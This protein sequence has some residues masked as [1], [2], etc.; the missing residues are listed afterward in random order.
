[1][2]AGVSTK[3][4]TTASSPACRPSAAATA[5]E[6]TNATPAR[7]KPAVAQT[8]Q[9]ILAATGSGGY[10]I[11]LA[12]STA[13]SPTAAPAGFSATSPTAEA[14]TETGL[15]TA[16][17]SPTAHGVV[18]SSPAAAALTPESSSPP[19][20]SGRAR[21]TSAF[22]ARATTSEAPTTTAPSAAT[23]EARPAS[24]TAH[25]PAAP[26]GSKTG[27][28]ICQR[29][30]A[31]AKHAA[32]PYG[33]RLAQEAGK[34]HAREVQTGGVSTYGQGAEQAPSETA[35]ASAT[36][37]ASSTAISP[38]KTERPSG[39]AI[40]NQPSTFIRANIGSNAPPPFPA[41][42][43]PMLRRKEKDGRSI[44][45]LRQAAKA[46]N[47]AAGQ[48]PAAGRAA[49]ANTPARPCRRQH[50]ASKVCKADTLRLARVPAV[51]VGRTRPIKAMRL[52]QMELSKP[53][54]PTTLRLPPMRLLPP[55]AARKTVHAEQPR[56]IKRPKSAGEA[57]EGRV[58]LS[59]KGVA[60][61]PRPASAP[62]EQ[63]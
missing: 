63:V 46:E 56:S 24:A 8:R 17:S 51:K 35:T 4:A 22:V 36:S 53:P 21:P 16:T 45:V 18:P 20:E 28:A 3:A 5:E 59:R 1:M 38:K 33:Q 62:A 25:G 44:G 15:G 49:T 52:G 57:M 13:T 61:R 50:T 6:A 43:C 11:S 14:P 31:V 23:H 29:A 9:T 55:A 54:Q 32:S 42:F 60:A 19:A 12:A 58:R 48:Q 37:Q 39:T 7:P 41:D 34:T 2:A 27:P 30:K 40:R 26:A 47:A 10:R